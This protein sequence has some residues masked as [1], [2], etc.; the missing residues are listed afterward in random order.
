[1][2]VTCAFNAS[3]GS[4]VPVV[5]HGPMEEVVL[6]AEREH[7]FLDWQKFQENC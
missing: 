5:T 2:T 6:K 3:S 4:R 7:A 1:M